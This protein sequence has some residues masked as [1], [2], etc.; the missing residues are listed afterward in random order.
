MNEPTVP[1]NVK[2]RQFLCDTYI[3][4]KEQGKA[5]EATTILVNANDEDYSNAVQYYREAHLYYQ[6]QGKGDDDTEFYKYIRN[7]LQCDSN[8]SIS[9]SSSGLEPETIVQPA[10][11][12]PVSK[13]KQLFMSALFLFERLV[14][15]IVMFSFCVIIIY[16]F[17]KE[18]LENQ[19]K[20]SI[21]KHLYL[22]SISGMVVSLI[23]LLV[24]ILIVSGKID[25]ETVLFPRML[26]WLLVLGSWSVHNTVGDENQKTVYGFGIGVICL[27]LITL[28]LKVSKWLQKILNYVLFLLIRVFG[29]NG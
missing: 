15:P 14:L 3:P 4:L 29:K 8:L 20:K 7:K 10:E 6:L 12:K 18:R 26:W 17:E 19:E 5:K 24:G 11:N 13:K 25:K 9:S 22:F 23:Y 28:W 1:E 21:T 2:I 27:S 16:E